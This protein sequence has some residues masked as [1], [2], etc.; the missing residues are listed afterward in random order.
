M[1][2]RFQV[3]HPGHVV[4]VLC[5]CAIAAG[6]LRLCLTLHITLVPYAGAGVKEP[7]AGWRLGPAELTDHDGCWTGGPHCG[8]TIR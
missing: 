5:S 2:R 3:Q 7:V 1:L 8:R 6:L 4:L